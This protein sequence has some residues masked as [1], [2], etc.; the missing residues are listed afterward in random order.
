MERARRGDL[1]DRAALGDAQLVELYLRHREAMWRTAQRSL[2]GT[3]VGGVSAEDV[4]QQVVLELKVRGLPA[5]R[6]APAQAEAYLLRSVRSRA[7]DAVRK[8]KRS[9]RLPDSDAFD[10]ADPGA[11]D[12]LAA[13]EQDSF[14]RH[15]DRLLGRLTPN[16]RFAFDDD[17]L[18][19]IIDEHLEYLG[20]DRDRPPSLATLRGDERHRAAAL[21]ELLEATWGAD[22]P[23]PGAPPLD[24]DP[25]HRTLLERRYREQVVRTLGQFELF[26]VNRG[27][28][29]RKHSFDR[30]YVSL[31]VA[32]SGRGAEDEDELTGA[33]VDVA[34]AF[35]NHPRVLLRGGAGAGKTTLLRWL[36]VS[37]ARDRPVSLWGDLVPFFLPLRQFARGPL[38]SVEQFPAA[39]AKAAAH[40]MP[41][42][43]AS[44][45]F[46]AGRALLL[47]D[48]V[49]ELTSPRRAETRAWL[50]QLVSAYPQA[51]Y[52]VTTRP[53][54][55]AE[56]WLTGSGFVTFDLLSLSGKGVR[57]FLSAWHDAARS[58]HE[59]DADMLRWLDACEQGLAFGE[60]RLDVRG[61]H[62]VACLKH[63]SRLAY[64]ACYGDFR[65]LDPLAAMP[66][67]RRLELIQNEVLRDLSPLRACRTLR[68]LELTGCPYVQDLS[69]LAATTVEHLALHMMRADLGTLRGAR[70]R[71]LTI[72]DPGLEH[73]LHLLP[74]DLP[75]RELTL[76]NLPHSRNLLGVERWRSLERLSVRGV[77]RAEEVEAL[78]GL[79]GLRHL[80][81][82]A[83]ESADG[84]ARL[85]ALPSLRRLDLDEVPRSER[86][87][88][89]TAL[90]G[91]P[92]LDVRLAG[93]VAATAPAPLRPGGRGA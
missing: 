63:L 28:A 81:L 84:L 75:L 87:A 72:R 41:R 45:L 85:Q 26:G 9:E 42:G 13:A 61:G 31:A 76:R 80:V 53:F 24:A 88:V 30:A 82:H 83:P 67:L 19:R 1:M 32:R 4:V 71:G 36:A 56:D 10:P 39:T 54:A 33:G 11:V 44:E 60:R 34:S 12:P 29:P 46:R 20:G 51:R 5:D 57:D 52:I 40:G 43:W 70:L 55:V 49:D 21:I 86:E 16:E 2:N 92:D 14:M 27:R 58:G 91:R 79:P 25:V 64:V 59:G 93:P 23:V 65:P 89:L 8:M 77:P 15:C 3:A 69:P 18:A 22:V 74:A 37:S 17:R 50:E 78:A 73:G 7:I 48:G 66:N 35:A 68:T 38:P 6:T 62:R 47:V 90:R